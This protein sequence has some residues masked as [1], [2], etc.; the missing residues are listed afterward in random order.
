MNKFKLS[1]LLIL[2][3]LLSQATYI[4]SK[5]RSATKSVSL[6]VV[7]NSKV[8]SQN[9]GRRTDSTKL[10]RVS[11]VAHNRNPKD[12]SVSYDIYFMGKNKKGHYKLMA[13]HSSSAQLKARQ[14]K[15]KLE[16]FVQEFKEKS[17]L[18]KR[19]NNRNRN[20]NNKNDVKFEYRGFLM[21]LKGE[22]GKIIQVDGEFS[23]MYKV[24]SAKTKGDIFNS[25]GE[26]IS[27]WDAER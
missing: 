12:V 6:D 24:I 8:D 9:N 17:T 3:S 15:A 23:R 21:I 2:C 20:R 13:K 25:K 18:T 22:D 26:K 10:V 7:S 1:V 14:Q 4:P 19:N 16:T 27:E 5:E 11:V